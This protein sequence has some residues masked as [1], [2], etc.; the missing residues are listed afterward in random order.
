VAVLNEG[1][2]ACSDICVK[3]DIQT[4]TQRI[5]LVCQLQEANA[6]LEPH[7]LLGQIVKH[8]IKEIGQHIL[9][10]GVTYKTHDGVKMY[11]RKFFKF[12]VNKPIDVRTKF[13]NAEDNMNNDVYLE[14]QIQNL[15]EASMILERVILEPSELYSCTEIRAQS[16]EERGGGEQEHVYL[17]PKATYQYL[18][19]LSLNNAN[20]SAI[21]HQ[22]GVSSIG[23]LDMSWRTSMGERGRLQTSPLQRMMPGYG[24][25]RLTIE[26]IPRKA[27]LQELFVIVCRLYNCSERSL[28]LVLT[29]DGALNPAMIHC[30]VSG[31]HLGQ[32]LPNNS[33]EF[34]LDI[35][36][37]TTG[38]QCISGIRLTDSLLRRTYEFDDIAQILIVE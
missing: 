13:Y 22:R 35:L 24:D 10:V 23:K 29:L 15:C 17:E 37:I 4:Q 9:V 1:A 19:C 33:I 27:K 25:L 14:A 30:S 11:F 36:S 21:G 3:A 2:H 34:S 6:L 20:P 38:L 18:Y 7:K 31:L 32:V 16:S 8:E 12:P 5:S 26:H 28:D